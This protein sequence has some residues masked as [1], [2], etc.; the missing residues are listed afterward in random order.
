MSVQ[1]NRKQS[2]SN[3]VPKEFKARSAGLK[4]AIVRNLIAVATINALVLSTCDG[5]CG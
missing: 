1:S 2:I 3:D 5:A 4:T